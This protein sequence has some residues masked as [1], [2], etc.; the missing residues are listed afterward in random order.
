[1]TSRKVEDLKAESLEARVAPTVVYDNGDPGNSDGHRNKPWKGREPI[2]VPEE[3]DIPPPS[4]P[5]D[6]IL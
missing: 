6:V 4:P 3:P 2:I 5:E 1:M